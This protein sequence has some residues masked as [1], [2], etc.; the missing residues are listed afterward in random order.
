[1]TFK[2][3]QMACSEAADRANEQFT[4]RRKIQGVPD[5]EGGSKFLS[6]ARRQIGEFLTSRTWLRRGRV[7]WEIQVRDVE[8]DTVVHVVIVGQTTRLRRL[9]CSRLL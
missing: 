5:L 4:D 2:S 8:D 6:D 3:L 7:T 1:M 9:C